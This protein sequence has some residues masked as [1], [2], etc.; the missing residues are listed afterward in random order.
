MGFQQRTDP[1]DKIHLVG[2]GAPVQGGCIVN[3]DFLRGKPFHTVGE[4][5]GTLV[6]KKCA[7]DGPQAGIVKGAG[8]QAVVI[9][10]FREV[11]SDTVAS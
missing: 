3:I 11:N 6:G 4:T 2:F 1:L 5:E 10:G 8:R 9:V 7:K